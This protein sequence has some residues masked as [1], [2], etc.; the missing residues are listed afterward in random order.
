M[1]PAKLRALAIEPALS[2]LPPRMNSPEAVRMLVAMAVQ[3]SALKYRRQ[4]L[5]P[6]RRWWEW[7]GPARG[8]WQFE[9]AGLRGVLTHPTSRNYARDVAAALGYELPN[10]WMPTWLTPLHESLMHND[11]L[12]CCMA[13]LLL[14]TLPEKM[15]QFETEGFEQYRVSWRPGAW[16]RGDEAHR[17]ELRRRWSR[18]WREAEEVI[19]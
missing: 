3:E 16:Y 4:V 13:R 10:G 14:W 5:K 1:T 9:P 8:W 15:A 2:L 6:G 17:A 18:A 12:A 7:R 11:V 19:A